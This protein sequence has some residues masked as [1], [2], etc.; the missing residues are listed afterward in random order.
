MSRKDSWGHHYD[1]DLKYSHQNS[2]SFILFKFGFLFTH[3][4]FCSYPV[5]CDTLPYE[6]RQSFQPLMTHISPE[7]LINLIDFHA[8]KFFANVSATTSWSHNIFIPILLL[9]NCIFDDKRESHHYVLTSSRLVVMLSLVILSDKFWEPQNKFSRS[10]S[11][12]P[13]LNIL[14]NS[15]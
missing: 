3:L 11:L 12:D 2:I 10:N 7:L 14:M 15:W 6:R 9:R 13:M 4:I 1:H 5:K 8:R